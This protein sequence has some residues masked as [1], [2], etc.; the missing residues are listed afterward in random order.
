[1]EFQAIVLCGEGR[2]MA[3]FSAVRASGMPKGLL[4][5]VNRPLVS[6]ALDWCRDGGF[7]RITV[8]TPNSF[9]GQMR[10]YIEEVFL[11]EYPGMRIDVVGTDARETGEIVGQLATTNKITSDFVVLPCDFISEAPASTLI[12]IHRKASDGSVLVTGFYY[13]NGFENIEKKSLVADYILHTPL[14]QRDP[15]LL[16]VYARDVVTA[17]KSMKVRMAM[18][19][20]NSHTVVSTNLLRS[21]IFFCSKD[22]LP[23]LE[24]IPTKGRTWNKVVRDVARRSWQH[25]DPLP[26]V[27]FRVIEEPFLRANNLSAYVEANRHVLK[28]NAKSQALGG[29]RKVN[30]APTGEPAKVATIGADSAVGRDTEIGE[31][32]SVKRSVLGNNCTIGRKCRITGCVVL[33]NVVLE[34]DVVLENCLIGKGAIIKQKSRLTSCH[35]EGS[36]HVP[37]NTQAKNEIL[38][39]VNIGEFAGDSESE[40][41]S[42]ME[43]EIDESELEQSEGEGI[44]DEDDLFER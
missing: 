36:F 29:T 40:T 32:T 15:R 14:A 44:D 17:S 27:A 28:L 43:S 7:G 35:V 38:E 11:R 33:D 20:R 37:K 26:G 31:K 42:E 22:V 2:R 41:E 9:L 8:V 4:P 18:L 10:T 21:S 3:P 39:N 24:S 19:W 25:R 6:F 30:A 34:D 13:R 12:D 1:M 23:L 16:D 5:V